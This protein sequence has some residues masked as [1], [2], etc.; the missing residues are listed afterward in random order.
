MTTAATH[1]EPRHLRADAR[2]N[3]ERILHAAGEVF[4]RCGAE[5]QMDDVA[6]RAGVGVGTLYRH[7]PT[8][9][10]LMGELVRQQ[11]EGFVVHAREALSSDEPAFQA[12]ATFLRRNAEAV[13]ADAATRY[14][15]GAGSAI[16]AAAEREREQ[17]APLMQE[18][19][20]R[21][22]AEGAVR[23]DLSLPDIPMIMCAIATSM[24]R[25]FDWR[26]L[27]ALVLDGI[28][29]P[30]ATPAAPAAP[31]GRVASG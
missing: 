18:L 12:L 5:T 10:A 15:M 9:P 26:R 20:D 3:R 22:Q 16:W 30:S 14:A 25:G 29:A 13:E 23:E 4:G 11:V 2:R 17:L 21:G 28:R 6:R 8:K 27:L 19:I 7:F 31:A 1:L 24:D